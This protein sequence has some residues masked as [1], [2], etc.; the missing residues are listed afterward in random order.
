MEKI[1]RKVQKNASV[2]KVLKLISHTVSAFSVIGF[3]FLAAIALKE[4]PLEIL[5]LVLVLGVPFA[6][7]TAVRKLINAPR[8]Y[9]TYNFYDTP[10]KSKRGSSFPSRHA[11]S[12]FSIGVVMCFYSPLFGAILLL[13]GSFMCCAR[14]LLGV[15]F[16]RDV[17][18]GAATGSISALL[19]A[20]LFTVI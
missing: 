1:L 14:V 6:A 8:P 18:C 20:I 9:E 2:S 16:I 19:G 3:A 15:H 12:A 4:S 5:K 7:V 10:P 11:H 17:I 13:F